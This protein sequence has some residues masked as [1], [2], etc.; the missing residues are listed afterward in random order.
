MSSLES[1]CLLREAARSTAGPGGGNG[2]ARAEDTAPG[3]RGP[4]PEP[5]GRGGPPWRRAWVVWAVAALAYVVALFHRTSLDVASLAAEHHLGVGAQALAGFTVVQLGVYL[6]MQVPS[7]VL[8]DR[9]GPRRMLTAGLGAMAGGAVL[10]GAATSPGAGLAA[11]A[12]VGLG[13]AC[14]FLNVLRLAQNWFPP[15]RYALMAALTGL[16]GGAGLLA[17]AEPLRLALSGWGWAPTFAG[18][19]VLTAALAATV[20]SVVRDSPHRRE[21][22][23]EASR[24]AEG[25]SA[26]HLQQY[27]G[28]AAVSPGTRVALWGAFALNAPFMVLAT[29]WGYPW[30]VE[31]QGAGRQAA[32]LLISAMIV[33][34]LALAPVM[35]LHAGAF[36]DRR[37]ALMLGASLLALSAWVLAL[38]WPGGR[39]PFLLLVVVMGAT[40]LSGAGAL[41]S[42]D[43][44]RASN[45]PANGGAA[46]GLVNTAGFGSA[47]LASYAAGL[48]LQHAGTGP[49]AFRL[50]FAPMVAVM[51]FGLIGC[52]SA[53]R[54]HPVAGAGQGLRAS[55]LAISRWRPNRIAAADARAAA[56]ASAH[57]SEYEPQ[58]TS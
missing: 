28:A 16:A 53:L 27:L 17:S 49:E 14:I 43:L 33:A 7:G 3:G 2:G 5:D 35:G 4:A 30:L 55:R 29:L 19:G 22:P 54:R 36:P 40:A 39:L 52:A 51:A 11:R 37:P 26:V 13:D 20:W 50:A 31:G 41:V 18:S 44:A 10:F 1:T 15:R 45:L 24:P 56:A 8:A 23:G 48:I 38:A 32:T 57:A 12:L 58:A 46:A 21:V 6:V 47:T 25:R 34:N 42:F 9:V